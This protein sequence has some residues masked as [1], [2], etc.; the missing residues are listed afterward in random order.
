MLRMWR[1]SILMLAFALVGCMAP[2]PPAP[3]RSEA[4]RIQRP[5][6]RPVLIPVRNHVSDSI[7]ESFPAVDAPVADELIYGAPGPPG[8]ILRSHLAE[9]DRPA[10][11]GEPPP[12]SPEPPPP[13]E[14]GANDESAKQAGAAR[15]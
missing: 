10:T 14:R 11:G 8:R 5:A 7:A 2:P 3:P 12:A 13:P 4:R 6:Y 1:I 9:P 15:R